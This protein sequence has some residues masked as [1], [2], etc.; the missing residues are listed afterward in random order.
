LKMIIMTLYFII[1]NRF[2]YYLEH[3]VL[4]VYRDKR[5][6]VQRKMTVFMPIKILL[7]VSASYL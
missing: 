3:N 4:D 6:L 1:L 7:L 5:K 2:T